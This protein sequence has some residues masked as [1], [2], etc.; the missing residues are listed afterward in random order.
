MIEV[1]ELTAS[2]DGDPVL[3]GVSLTVRP[4]EF[5]LLTGPNGAGKTTLVRHL[6]GL[7]EPDSGSVVVD[8]TPVAEDPVHARRSVGM[9]FQ[10]P[11]DQFVGST[12][13][14]DVAFGP[15]NLGL[16]RE[17]ITDRVERALETVGLEG[18]RDERLETLSGGERTRVALAGVLAMEPQYVVLDESL[19]SLDVSARTTLLDHLA[20]LVESGRGVVLV[21]HDLRDAWSTTDRVIALSGGRVAVDGPPEPHREALADLAVVPRC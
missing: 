3:A 13:G 16:D 5:V 8:G 9:V 4:G 2:Y 19:G 20:G 17:T 7:Q 14:G 10:A 15:E 6:N 21:T 11:G 1:R 18:R 12:V